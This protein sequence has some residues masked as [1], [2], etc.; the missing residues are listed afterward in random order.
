MINKI[1]HF[2][3][4]GDSDLPENIIKSWKDIHPNFT[5]KVWRDKDI[6]SLK[7]TNYQHYLTANKRYNQKSDISRYE[8]LYRFGGIYVDADIFCIKNITPLIENKDFFSI[9]EKKGLISNS[10]IG[11]TKNNEVMKKIIDHIH[12]NYNYSETVWKC[13]GPLLF[14]RILSGTN[15]I[16]ETPEKFN[17][18]LH[19]NKSM[20]FLNKHG[21]FKKLIENVSF[22]PSTNRVMKYKIDVNN[23]YGIQL[24][25]GGK[26][27]NYN[28]LNKIS[29]EDLYKNI[30]LYV[31]LITNNDNGRPFDTTFYR[32]N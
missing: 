19:G 30:V 14:T 24:F 28:S 5:I 23:I 20:Y 18:R 22:D 8:I 9:Y 11:C 12:D 3:W 25:L 29:Y 13:T 15:I 27:N 17:Y 1:L 16:S 26:K 4:L 32:M 21:K 6:E 10:I 2:I 7:L 31:S